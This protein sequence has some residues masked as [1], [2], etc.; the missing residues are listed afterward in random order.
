MAF[1]TIGKQGHLSP[2][3]LCANCHRNG[4]RYQY[5]ISPLVPSIPQRNANIVAAVLYTRDENVIISSLNLLSTS[6]IGFLSDLLQRPSC[7]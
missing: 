7:V 1:K 5:A 3:P 4:I 6:L 2:Q